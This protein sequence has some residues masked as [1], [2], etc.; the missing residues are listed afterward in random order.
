MDTPT[1]RNPMTLKPALMLEL[2]S[3]NNGWYVDN[4]DKDPNDDKP[5][6]RLYVRKVTDNDCSKTVAPLVAQCVWIDPTAESLLD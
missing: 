5:G 3:S 6:E 1:H 4:V 2:K